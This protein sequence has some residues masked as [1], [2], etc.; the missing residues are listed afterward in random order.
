MTRK[1][2]PCLLYFFHRIFTHLCLLV[3]LHICRI[4]NVVSSLFSAYHILY[5]WSELFLKTIS[6]YLSIPIKHFLYSRPERSLKVASITLNWNDIWNWLISI[7]ALNHKPNTLIFFVLRVLISC[8]LHHNSQGI[9]LFI[10]FWLT[11]GPVQ[12]AHHIRVILLTSIPS[13]SKFVQSVCGLLHIVS[14]FIVA[15]LKHFK[16]LGIFHLF[17]ELLNT[18]RSV[19]HKLFKLVDHKLEKFTTWRLEILFHFI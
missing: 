13:L 16:I 5:G 3:F 14:L 4:H 15:L 2:T 1:V 11:T 8:R 7:S 9:R 12:S 17:T 18:V 10:I 6:S 19:C